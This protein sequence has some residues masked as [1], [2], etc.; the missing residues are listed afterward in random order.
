MNAL[1]MDQLEQLI[2]AIKSDVEIRSWDEAATK[3]G[4]VL[5][6]LNYLGWNTYDVKEVTPEYSVE[7]QRVDYALRLNSKPAVFIEVKR[8]SKDL[9]GHQKQLLQYSFQCGVDLAILTNGITWQFFLPL[10]KGDW[11]ERNFY[12]LDMSEQPADIIMSNF[13][14]LL[15]RQNIATQEAAKFAQKLHEG[16]QRKSA[17]SESLPQAWNRAVSEPDPELISLIGDLAA[18]ISGF[19]PDE[20][21]VEDFLLEHQHELT[22]RLSLPSSP[23]LRDTGGLPR[24]WA[25]GAEDES[26]EIPISPDS[27]ETD[28]V[29]TLHELGGRAKRGDVMQMIWEKR[30]RILSQNGYQIM[31]RKGPR[32]KR[33]IAY[34]ARRAKKKGLLLEADESGHGIWQLT[35]LGMRYAPRL[36]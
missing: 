6:V 30:K 13:D 34:A 32:W 36:P 1:A 17:L 2:A 24:F 22:F 31:T 14:Q 23:I 18:R 12:T 5:R 27:I 10:T 16:N 4:I 8:P 33:L 3:Q 9:E 29:K 20:E 26:V 19:R 21:E 15:S 11:R 25:G 28:L 35:E 7:S